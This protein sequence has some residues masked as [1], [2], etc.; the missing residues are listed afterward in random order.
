MTDRRNVTLVI[1]GLIATILA[2]LGSWDYLS[3]IGADASLPADV[4][5]VAVGAL[6]AILATTRTTAADMPMLPPNE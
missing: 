4:G 1:A 5:K 3:A 2:C 6:G